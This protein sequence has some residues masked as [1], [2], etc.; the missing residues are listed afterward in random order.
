MESCSRERCTLS[1][2]WCRILV[3]ALPLFLCLLSGAG[4]K[5]QSEAGLVS[6]P[7]RDSV[8]L[9]EQ[10]FR[11]GRIA[12]PGESAAALR[13]KAQKQKLYSRTLRAQRFALI[14]NA[15]SALAPAIAWRSLGPAPVASDST[16]QGFQDYGLVAGRTT[17]VVVDP[18]DSTGNTVYVGGAYGGLWRSQ[19][20]ASGTYGNPSAVTWAALTDNQPTLAV[21]SIALQ[22]LN[23]NNNTHLSRTI[24]VGTGEANDSADSYYG[25]GILRSTDEGQSWSLISSADNGSHPFLG[26]AAGKIAFTSVSGK[27]NIVVAGFGA[28]APGEF[29]GGDTGFPTTHG[30]YYSL[31]SGATWHLADVKDAAGAATVPSSARSVVFNAANQTFYAAIRRHGFYSSTNGVNWT[32]LA[33][34][35]DSTGLGLNNATSCPASSNSTNCPIVRGELAVVPGRNEM[36]VWYMDVSGGF[37]IEKG[38]WKT[39]DGGNNWTSISTAGIDCQ[40][41]TGCGVAQGAYNLMLAA[42]PNAAGTDLYAGAV[43]LFKCSINNANPT[44]LA[45]PFINLTHVYGCSPLAAPSHVHPDQHGLDYIVVGGKS[46]IY[47]ANDGGI[48]RALDGY[49]GLT[50]GSCA[51]TNRFDSLNHSIGSLTQFVAFSQHPT[52]PNTLLGGTQDNGSPATASATTSTSWLNVNNGDGGFNVINPNSPNNWFTS[53]PDVGGGTLDIEHCSL[54]IGC[55]AQDFANGVVITSAK[56]QGDDGA[57]YFPY[58]LD[59]QASSQM[60]VGTCRVWRGPALGN[61][62]FTAL[63]LNFDTDTPTVC[64]GS[65]LN[66]VTAIAAGGPKDGQGFSRVVY[67]TTF[68][69]GPY[70]PG[71]SVFATT[72]AGSALM[73]NVTANINPDGYTISGVAVDTSDPTGQTAYVTIMGFHVAH[74]FRTSNAGQTWADF[75]GIGASALPDS[76]A[77]AVVVAP[78]A[79]PNSGVVFVGTDAGVFSSPTNSPNWTEVG[80]VPGPGASGFLPNTT[81]VAL[82]LFRSGGQTQLRAAT[83]GRG[84][85]EITVSLVPDFQTSITN[86]PLTIYAG[87]SAAFS[88]TI[89]AAFGYNSSVAL[90]CAAGTTQ[91]PAGCA[92]SPANVTPTAN[93]AQISVTSASIGSTGDYSF[94]L[95]GTG[96]DANTTT[97]DVPLVLHV[98]DF[99]L[100]TPN[101]SGVAVPRGTIS[102]PIAFQA[103]A[104]G[105]FAGTV[106]LS[107]S[108]LPTGAACNFSPSASVSP[109]SAVPVNLTLTVDVA[110][111][112]NTGPYTITIAATVAGAPAPK[113]QPFTL[114]VQLNPDFVLSEPVPF[115]IVKSGHTGTGPIRVTARDG[116]SATVNLS[117][118][119][120]TTSCGVVPTSVSS[121]P[122]NPSVTVDG[123]GLVGDFQLSVTGISG[124]R[125]HGLIVPFSVG[126]FS[127]SVVTAPGPVTPGQ[128]A[129]AAMRIVPSFGYTGDI[130]LTCNASAIP[131]ANCTTTPAGPIAVTNANAQPFTTDIAVDS[132]TPPGNYSVAV[133]GT[134]QSGAPVASAV[135]TISVVPFQFSSS[136][137]PQSVKAGQPA[138]YNLN[139]APIAGNFQNPVS[140]A[141]SN[142]PAYA[143]CSFS[144]PS[145]PAGSGGGSVTLTISTVE[146]TPGALMSRG[147]LSLLA[148]SLGIAGLLV[149]SRLR[150]SSQ[151]RAAGCAL[152]WTTLPILVLI[153]CGGGAGGGGNPPPPPPLPVSISINP[154]SATVFISGTQ[155]FSATVTNSSNTQVSWDVNGTTGGNS[156]VG[157]IDTSGLYRAPAA[158]PATSVTVRAVPQ[159]DTSKSAAASV[160]VK[161]STPRG[162]YQITVT[163]AERSGSATLARSVVVDL[164]V[165]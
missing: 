12:P 127:I 7:D 20:A 40:N 8:R 63:S 71:G 120:P 148:F 27:T 5:A 124:S 93:G 75:S 67:A 22:P 94:N 150:K 95:R 136:T 39:T 85:W 51:G 114:N 106:N 153:A 110:A 9:R 59:P 147:N 53:H 137:P 125:T 46:I 98:V 119:F 129:T 31:D 6:E 102:S 121:Y 33:K 90:S 107:C 70:G 117:C 100:T 105:S 140:F 145:L 73:A 111:S 154:T 19:N 28:S 44:C 89:S 143:S 97:H 91:P 47:L 141:C 108:G 139:I 116:F 151:R 81:V 135:L 29:T 80:P 158:L 1:S 78:G 74:V 112:T 128:S 55:H 144:P 146:S 96:S 138:T 159:A 132:A 101:P 142:L 37:D 45:N 165:Q 69:A 163:A 164:T 36:Y 68:G 115:P 60:L 109:T 58:M 122:A 99:N 17:A 66:Q 118:S 52:D 61:G 83:H 3:A 41:E 77:N 18:A 65:E 32:R 23:V 21:G 157:T 35:P 113:T 84:I 49:T 161:A 88:G 15:A 54:G 126:S 64:T 82:G 149:T 76:P 92:V 30:L 72:N 48:Y 152:A 86:T 57:F 14:A 123:T 38:I 104:S 25:L 131:G 42:L 79:N 2:R 43:N 134:D 133:T 156:T 24:L 26:M 16:G 130:D 62:T 103:T 50:N 13:Y 160:T 155:R 4:A 10:W 34:Q 11:R 162:R 87:Q 56:L